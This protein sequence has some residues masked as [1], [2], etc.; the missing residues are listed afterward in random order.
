MYET[1]S[2]RV[3]PRDEYGNSH[4]D[5][6]LEKVEVRDDRLDQVRGQPGGAKALLGEERNALLRVLVAGNEAESELGSVYTDYDPERLIG[7]QA[8][9]SDLAIAE[10]AA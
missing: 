5:Y 3:N 9:A 1:D 4:F 7:L 6:L 2:V 8:L 10:V